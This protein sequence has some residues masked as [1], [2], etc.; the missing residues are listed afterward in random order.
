MITYMCCC[1]GSAAAMTP[2][3]ASASASSRVHATQGLHKHHAGYFKTCVAGRAAVT[4]TNKCLPRCLAAMCKASTAPA[5]RKP[6]HGDVQGHT[7]PAA[8]QTLLGVQLWNH[9]PTLQSK[10]A[11]DEPTAQ[12]CM[13]TVQWTVGKY[14]LHT[15]TTSFGQS[16]PQSTAGR[17]QTHMT[18]ASH[19]GCLGLPEV[20][21]L[22]LEVTLCDTPGCRGVRYRQSAPPGASSV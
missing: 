16:N 6:G 4:H 20:S 1:T 13:H 5:Y 9:K 18:G 11:T 17:V 7:T 14:Q 10:A 21:S 3:H 8:L 2:T 12:C 15:H 19:K 22:E